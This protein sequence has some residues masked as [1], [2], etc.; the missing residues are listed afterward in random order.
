[1]ERVTKQKNEKRGREVTP[2]PSLLTVPLMP[3]GCV[4]KLPTV[5]Q[6]ELVVGVPR[7]PPQQGQQ[8]PA[9]NHP[10]GRTQ[11]PSD[12][13]RTSGRDARALNISLG[14]HWGGQPRL[15]PANITFG[16]EITEDQLAGLKL[17][18]PPPQ[19]YYGCKNKLRKGSVP[20]F[21]CAWWSCAFYFP[22][23]WLIA[24]G[25]QTDLGF[26]VTRPLFAV[27]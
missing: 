2:S 7:C 1:M 21:W 20:Q 3:P 22:I 6:Q 19:P 13:A 25:W 9:V 23:M 8:V 18:S 14:K 11:H 5:M 10:A 26:F 12:K 24:P 17:L 27:R 16:C 15:S 4:Q